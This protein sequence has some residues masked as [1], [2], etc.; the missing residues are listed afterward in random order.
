MDAVRKWW[1]N[2]FSNLPTTAEEIEM[3]A[4]KSWKPQLEELVQFGKIRLERRGSRADTYTDTLIELGKRAHVISYKSQGTMKEPVH[5]TGRKERDQKDQ[6]AV[7]Y[8][9]SKTP[10]SIKR[11]QFIILAKHSQ[12]T[13]FTGPG[14]MPNEEDLPFILATA[15]KSYSADYPSSSLMKVRFWRQTEGNPN[16]GFTAGMDTDNRAW[17][18]D[19]LRGTVM[20]IGPKFLANSKRLTA[21]T[22]RALV[23]RSHSC[24]RGWQYMPKHGL[25]RAAEVCEIVSFDHQSHCHLLLVIEKKT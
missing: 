12:S 11:N 22:K 10:G 24:M 5:Y 19:V 13:K 21:Q 20:Q 23:E 1:Q 4:E 15:M 7:E 3:A 17:T 6:L 9:D 18:G 2:Y 14:F 16:R 8:E 25:V